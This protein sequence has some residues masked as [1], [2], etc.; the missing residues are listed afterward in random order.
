V[1]QNVNPALRLDGIVMTMFDP[2]TRLSEQVVGEVRR[3]FGERVYETI[4]P[5]TVRLSEAPGFGQ[6]ITIYDPRSK[7]AESYRELAREVVT[8]Q[9]IDEP[10]PVFEEL[11]TL[12]MSPPEPHVMKAPR[13][14]ARP[15]E[16]EP[17]LEEEEA[18]RTTV[19]EHEVSVQV[20]RPE[21]P[22]GSAAGGPRSEVE[23]EALGP[24][25][26]AQPAQAGAVAVG[27][28]AAASAM[29]PALEGVEPQVQ[30]DGELGGRA[31]SERAMVPPPRETGS[32]AALGIESTPRV[33]VAEPGYAFEL[34]REDAAEV[35][36][37]ANR[38]RKRR[39]WRLFRRGG[40]R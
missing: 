39:R 35:Q 22:I 17:E 7:G 38:E 25:G 15:V 1:Q 37:T 28:G 14:L 18:L 34:G 31:E 10:M 12:S 24:P 8:R 20:D 4:I 32:Q 13:P 16:E 23:V 26:P 29:G 36:A 27:R 30:V 5:R 33:T 11:A 21:R 40:N 2:R 19:E 3:F 9:P 6:P